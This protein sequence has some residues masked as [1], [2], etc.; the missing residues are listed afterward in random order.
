[1]TKYKPTVYKK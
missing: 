1:M